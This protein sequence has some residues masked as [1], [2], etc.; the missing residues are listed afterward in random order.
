MAFLLPVAPLL[1][2]LA[3]SI[4][5]APGV[6]ISQ[7]AQNL[8]TF[9]WLFGFVTSIVLYTA[10]SK[11]FPDKNSLVEETIWH[12]DAVEGIP[13][14]VENGGGSVEGSGGEIKGFHE[15]DAKVF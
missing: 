3:Y 12:L 15:S 11:I 4:T 14:D 1:P 9:D 7:G 2:G 8:Y 10:L 5:G 6:Q 13:S